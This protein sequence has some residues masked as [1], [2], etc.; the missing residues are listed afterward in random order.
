MNVA[1]PFWSLIKYWRIGRDLTRADLAHRVGCSVKTIEK[2]ESGERRPSKLLASLL[3]QYLGIPVEDREN[4]VRLARGIDVLDQGG[5]ADPGLTGGPGIAGLIG[6]MLKTAPAHLVLHSSHNLPAYSSS[7][8]GREA[9]V[10]ALSALLLQPGVRLLSVTGPPGIGK[11]RLA[12][13]VARLASVHM[14]DS[15]LFIDL[16]TA[17]DPDVLASSIAAVVGVREVEGETLM[18]RLCRYFQSR[19]ILLFLDKSVHRAAVS[20][21]VSRLIS[22]APYLKVVVTCRVPLGVQGEHSFRVPALAVPP[23]EQALPLSELLAL[24]SARLFFERAVSVDPD[25]S[26]SEED[27]PL[28]AEICRRV[29]GVPRQIEQLAALAP[30]TPLQLL[31]AGF[32]DEG[33][34]VVMRRG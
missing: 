8:I 19:Q 23:S 10:A 9:E 14:W 31:L 32:D 33:A 1:Q 6:N 15:A 18:D 34:R 22:V 28:L 11:T 21:F 7:F 27:A 13:E 24:D 26:L 12:V 3:A 5:I 20:R 25:F 29:R 30:T 2:I 4:F 16:A 17:S